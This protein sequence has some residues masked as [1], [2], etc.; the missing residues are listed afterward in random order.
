[1]KRTLVST[2]LI[3]TQMAVDCELVS[4]VKNNQLHYWLHLLLPSISKFSFHKNSS[5]RCVTVLCSELLLLF[6]FCSCNMLLAMLFI[7]LL[8]S[9]SLGAK[10][11]LENDSILISTS[12]SF[13]C[14]LQLTY[15]PHLQVSMVKWGVFPCL[16]SAKTLNILTS[17]Q[18]KE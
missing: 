5:T 17:K 3:Q 15:P 4:F 10:R 12:Q 16:I 8:V 1:M 14:I 7:I 6:S 9:R 2:G 13:K 18:L 11:L